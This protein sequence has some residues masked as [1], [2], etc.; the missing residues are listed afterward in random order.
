MK[1]TTIT[2]PEQIRN[3]K[4]YVE[5][6]KRG[7]IPLAVPVLNINEW[8][9]SK[10]SFIPLL[11][12]M[13]MEQLERIIY[14]RDF[15]VITSD[16]DG[17]ERGQILNPK[18]FN[19]LMAL[20]KKESDKIFAA[21]G[22]DAVLLLLGTLDYKQMCKDAFDIE[23]AGRK[24][25]NAL[26]DELDT[27]D[28]DALRESIQGKMFEKFNE[29][30]DEEADHA[31]LLSL[32]EKTDEEARLCEL[33]EE[34]D[35]ALKET[36]EAI[37]KREAVFR[38]LNGG[39]DKLLIK[40]I[41]IFPYE[42]REMLRIGMAND[43]YLMDDLQ[44]LYRKVIFANKRVKKVEELDAPPVIM[45]NERRMLQERVDD[46]IANGRRGAPYMPNREDD[47]CPALSLTDIVLRSVDVV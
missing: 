13:S 15:V 4:K 16:L 46:L 11:L 45:M 31:D 29:L 42:I 22:A 25:L 33:D 6:E 40:E 18:T 35:I 41:E 30:P 38:M 47:R 17:Y 34:I 1:R 8:R 32:I 28:E 2:D 39:M 5:K 37:C 27:L 19:K 44:D 20:P 9:E 43:P 23:T 10:P 24:R 21:T 3:L 14:F 36:G 12:N 26:Y 7:V